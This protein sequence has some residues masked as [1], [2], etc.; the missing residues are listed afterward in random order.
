MGIGSP[1]LLGKLVRRTAVTFIVALGFAPSA[2]ADNPIASLSANA[3]STSATVSVAVAPTPSV[4]VKAA[5]TA[6]SPSQ[7]PALAPAA[8]SAPAVHAALGTTRTTIGVTA[9]TSA[10]ITRGRQFALAHAASA[11]E[12]Q[13]NLLSSSRRRGA[14]TSRTAAA[15]LFR[16]LT[17]VRTSPTAGPAPRAPRLPQLPAP[18]GFTAAGSTASS[19]AVALLLLALGMELAVLA[20]PRLGRRL[21]LLASAPRPYAYLLDLERPD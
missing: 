6:P 19:A 8:P 16:Q 13:T 10:S 11:R 1:R 14:S 15:T 21:A 20:M 5:L 4:D 3:G 18:V 9:P 2:F 17:T 7:L 12:S